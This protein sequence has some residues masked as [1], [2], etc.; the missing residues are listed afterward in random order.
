MKIL[1]ITI[2]GYRVHQDTTLELDPSRNLIG[3]PNE[4]GKS[5][6]IEAV[7]RALFLKSSVSGSAQKSMVSTL[8]GGQPEVEVRFSAG[9]ATY[10]LAKRFSGSSGSTTLAAEGGGTLSGSEAEDRLAE[11]LGVEPVGGGRGVLERSASQW[12]HLWVKQGESAQ[13]PSEQASKERDSLVARLKEEGGAAAMESELDSRVSR[14]FKERC[15]EIFKANSQPRTGSELAKAIQ[16]LG[17]ARERLSAA[18]AMA[19]RLRQAAEDF[20]LSEKVVA[21]KSEKLAEVLAERIAARRRGEQIATLRM[22]EGEKRAHCDKV[23]AELKALNDTASNMAETSSKLH[24]KEARHRPSEAEFERCRTEVER[25]KEKRQKSSESCRLAEQRAK[26]SRLA[27]ERENARRRAF[28]REV[29]LA[30]LRAESDDIA[31]AKS[32]VADLEF[33]IARMPVV[34]REKIEGIKRFEDTLAKAEAA[35]QA[36]AAGIEV[37]ASK[38]A[39]SIGEEPAPIGSS[40]VITEDTTVLVG[41][42]AEIR[43]SPG[44]GISLAEARDRVEAARAALANSLEQLGLA[45]VPQAE[46]A[47]AGRTHLSMRLADK[48]AAL[49]ARKADEVEARLTEALREVETANA[50]LARRTSAAPCP[51]GAPASLAEATRRAEAARDESERLEEEEAESKAN[52]EAIDRLFQ[53]C[54]RQTRP[55]TG[56]DRCRP[57]RDGVAAREFSRP[58]KD[59]WQQEP[60]R[61]ERA[62]QGAQAGGGERRASRHSRRIADLAT[63]RPRC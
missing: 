31:K 2:R 44:G 47:Y 27:L 24:E 46:E 38:A 20:A 10:R 40:R 22:A 41:D 1:S 39:I 45:A 5:T 12:A 35:L 51:E 49:A 59:V 61:G 15:D 13:N 6:L 54:Q 21:E 50:E 18:Q 60:G 63:R 62:G 33:Q 55:P 52:L 36:M 4:S 43:V 57:A 8:H 29:E 19:D 34:T 16:A 17:E 32:E 28:E 25:L 26:H 56:F 3:G 9:G 7:H 37:I 11:V 14:F 48:R 42:V 58:R 30:R 23:A 53:K